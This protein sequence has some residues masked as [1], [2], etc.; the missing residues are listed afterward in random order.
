M[1]KSSHQIINVIGILKNEQKQFQI[2]QDNYNLIQVKLSN[3]ENIISSME[4]NHF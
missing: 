4:K 2:I 1:I 3:H